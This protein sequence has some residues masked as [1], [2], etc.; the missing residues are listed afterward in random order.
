[1]MQKTADILIL[2]KH[3]IIAPGYKLGGFAELFKCRLREE[4]MQ[5]AGQKC[6]LCEFA[7]DKERC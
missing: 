4:V 6:R 3:N 5:P 2:K 1:M 7:D